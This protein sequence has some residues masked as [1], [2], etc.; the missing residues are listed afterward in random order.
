M[1]TPALDL[2][3]LRRDPF[4]VKVEWHATLPSTNDHA[5]Q[6][7]M[8]EALETPL[9]ILADEQTAGRGRGS[10]RWWSVAGG[11]TFS[12]VLD[13]TR[14][15]TTSLRTEHWPRV[16]LTAGVALCEALVGLA[17]YLDCG[18]KWP[19]DVLISGRKVAGILVEIP[20][21]RPPA[22][23]RLVLGIGINVNNSLVEAPAEIQAR[24]IALCDATG[25]EFDPTQLLSTWLARFADNLV[26]LA[27]DDRQLPNRWQSRCVLT[28]KTV[29]LQAGERTI[30]G[31]CQGIDADGALLLDTP[32]GPERLYGGVLVRT[33]P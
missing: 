20:P 12:L 30:R 24:G 11:L 29:E 7:A 15:G 9:L 3:H 14:I 26:A 21:A 2:E 10:N 6:L 18:L 23:R 5:L 13:P 33:S 28:G 1:R 16:A 27:A 31:I 22:P 4:V 8:L 17:P 19:N 32:G 25:L